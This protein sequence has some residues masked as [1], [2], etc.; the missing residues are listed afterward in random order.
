MK[1][2]DPNSARIRSLGM[3]ILSRRNKT[4]TARVFK[5]Y[6]IDGMAAD[7]ALPAGR[8]QSSGPPSVSLSFSAG[9]GGIGF[10]GER[11]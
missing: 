6:G 9:R 2:H 10:A 3:I 7:V 5:R 1:L 11:D 4:Q 8:E